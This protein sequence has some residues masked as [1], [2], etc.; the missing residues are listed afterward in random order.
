MSR[1]RL[2]WVPY[3]YF[4]RV[5]LSTALVLTIGPPLAMFSPLFR[6]LFDLDYGTVWRTI[7][8]IALVSL[9]AFSGAWT[10]LATTWSAAYNA[11]DRF[12][13]AR[14]E[15][16]TYPITWPEREFFAVFALPTIIVSVWYTS[17]SSGTPLLILLA[18]VIIGGAGAVTVLYTARW[19]ADRLQQ[20]ILED[21]PR[22]VAARTVGKAVDTLNRDNVRDGYFDPAT[23]ELAPGHMLA[24]T[25]FAFSLTL[26]VAIGIGKWVRLGYDTTVSTLAC[27]LLLVLMVC[28][29]GAGLTFLLDR[30]RVSFVAVFAAI[31]LFVGMLPLPGSDHTYRTFART[32][33]T[34]PYAHQV[35]RA[36]TRTPIVVAATG[37]GIQAA[38]WTARVL[39]GIDDALPDDLRD[40]YTHSIRL[41][42][43]VSGGGVGA[44]YFAE[45]YGAAGFD[46]TNLRQVVE[47]AQSSTLDD[48]A[49]GAAYPDALATFFPPVRAMFGDRGQAL[50]TAWTRSLEVTRLLSDWRTGVWSD[51]RPANI[52]NATLVDTGERLLIGTSRL[53]WRQHRGLRNFEDLYKDREIQVVTAARLAAS[54]T[55]VS[56]ATR[57][58]ERGDDFHVVDGGYYDDYGMATLSEWLDEGLEG[59][60]DV[61]SFPRVLVIQI[62]S[63]P[64]EQLARPDRWHG[65][66]YQLWAPA[67]TLLNVRAT[68]QISH[69]DGEFERLQQLWRERKVQI[70]NVI[71]RFCGE[72]PP[73][74]WHLTRREKDAI[75]AEWQAHTA[76]GRPELQAVQA[77]LRGQ[78]LPVVENG[79]PYDVPLTP[80]P[81]K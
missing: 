31:A 21:H 66:L 35:L 25:V 27:V 68:G 48:V 54:F 19:V 4:L 67:E 3:F 34:S 23:G 8:S 18:G 45:R 36:G 1:P 74:S 20:A 32:E 73:L 56:P 53:G 76:A 63:D 7:S 37:G 13:T 28:W 78:P 51:L 11:P 42:S 49:W 16:I 52:F 70:A 39:T 44:M 6:G 58:S 77:F 81:V 59:L 38:A 17:W 46:R 2:W 62:R 43:T 65:P 60:G 72:H 30:Y 47:K 29:L 24:I 57:P 26:Y 5:Q 15:F 79:K 55:Y 12:G 33:D 69:N 80:C 9:A 10:L 61:A 22:G 14:I 40:E 41:L 50:E 75:E 71:F 64:G